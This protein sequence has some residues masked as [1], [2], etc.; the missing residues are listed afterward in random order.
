MATRRLVKEGVFYMKIGIFDSGIG[1]LNILEYAMKQ[2]ELQ[3]EYIFYADI[4]NVP[5]SY[6]TT[7]EIENYV[8]TAVDTMISMG[9]E[10]VVLACNTATSVTI[11]K[12]RND[13]N[14]PIVGMEPAIK[15]ALECLDSSKDLVLVAAT[16]VTLKL[17]KFNIL[18][19]KL[20]G[21]KNIIFCPLP[22]LVEFAEKGCFETD[23]VLEYIKEKLNGL[24]IERIQ[25][26]VLG[27]THFSYFKPAFNELF[28]NRISFFD[29]IVGTINQLKKQAR[30]CCEKKSVVTFVESGRKI[31]DLRIL[32]YM[33]LM[34]K[35]ER[36]SRC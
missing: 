9:A 14:I 18:L 16:P 12:L 7:R 17:E 23:E 19:D 21:R 5:Y 11:N 30:I 8:T 36:M 3:C 13:Y 1:G 27:C 31:S 6:K 35:I 28:N 26:I 10:L 32:Y 4:D 22:K 33:D 2:P 29:G 34:K 24:E 25:S 15:P 20:D